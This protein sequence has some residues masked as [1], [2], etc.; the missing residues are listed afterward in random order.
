MDLCE[1]VDAGIIHE[2]WLYADDIVGLDDVRYAELLELKPQYDAQRRR[3]G[4][5]LD[6]CAGNGCFDA[7][8][9]ASVPSHCN[10][11]VRILWVNDSRGIGCGIENFDHGF[12]HTAN[13]G[14]IPYLTG[15]FREFADFDLNSRYGTPFDS[16]Y[17]CDAGMGNRC[18]TYTG[19]QSLDYDTGSAR[20]SITSY[21][22]AC[23]QS[24]VPP[25]GRGH[26]DFWG[27]NPTVTLSTCE[28]FRLFDGPDGQDQVER[29]SSGKFT[30]F[31]GPNL[32][33]GEGWHVWWRQNFPGPGSHAK[34][35][36]GSAMLSW[37]PFLFY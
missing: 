31:N 3:V 29:F 25:N 30:I 8:D 1:L 37:W 13:A 28:H 32:D 5:G 22:P 10:R 4:T 23:G 21:L 15:Y 27:D 16:W 26:Y 6:A 2:L 34:A 36:D 19:L 14:L 12:E 18:I 24:H 33:C 11:T 9:V 17:S 20:G 7:E 35:Q